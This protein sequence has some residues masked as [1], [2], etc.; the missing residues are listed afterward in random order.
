MNTPNDGTALK[1][2][3]EWLSNNIAKRDD[4]NGGVDCPAVKFNKVWVA[5]I[6]KA[7]EVGRDSQKQAQLISWL[8]QRTDL[9]EDVREPFISFLSED[10]EKRTLAY[11]TDGDIDSKFPETSDDLGSNTTTT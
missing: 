4:T 6:A 9:E 11:L 2:A 3:F 7:K 1:N 5:T 8:S 10:L